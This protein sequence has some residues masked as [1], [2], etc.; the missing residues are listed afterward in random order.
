[1][2]KAILILF[3]LAIAVVNTNAQD[4]KAAKKPKTA[5]Q[6]TEKVMTKL[7]EKLSLTDTQKP[8]VKEI[9][10]KREQQQE[11][12]RKQFEKDQAALK[13]ANKKVRKSSDEELK[14]ALT[15]EQIEKLKQHRAEMREKHKA[16]KGA[17]ANSEPDDEI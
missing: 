4:A 9:I 2:K 8:K 15:P 13:E 1:M 10:L 11:A 12:N 17:A 7:N 6:R 5:E 14:A 16:K 3:A